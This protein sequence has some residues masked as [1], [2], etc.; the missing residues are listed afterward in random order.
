M[1][2]VPGYFDGLYGRQMLRA[3]AALTVEGG[4][5]G[6]C[7][8]WTGAFSTS[9]GVKTYPALSMKV[10]GVRRVLKTHRVSYEAAY[11]PIPPGEQVHHRCGRSSCVRPEHLQ[12]ATARENVA[13]ML[14][15]RTLEARI[16]AL[17]SALRDFMP[18][19]PALDE[20]SD[21]DDLDFDDFTD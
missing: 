19:H 8:D 13:E 11:G 6:E 1:N 2:H 7:W 16:A 5:E 17:E 4:D 12:A 3:I 10:G 9:R 20:G 15:R 21:D 14:V 18:D